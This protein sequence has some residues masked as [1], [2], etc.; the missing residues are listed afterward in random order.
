MLLFLMIYYYVSRHGGMEEHGVFVCVY[1]RACVLS[2]LSAWPAP[3]GPV[4]F[5]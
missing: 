2:S 5:P 1:A 3:Q 4:A